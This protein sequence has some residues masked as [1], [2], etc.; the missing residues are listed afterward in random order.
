MLET[1]IELELEQNGRNRARDSRVVGVLD[2][3]ARDG[4]DSYVHYFIY[5]TSA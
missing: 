5:I 3:G 2:L 1:E 4:L